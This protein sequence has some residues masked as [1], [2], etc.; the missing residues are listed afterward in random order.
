MKK[1]HPT[2]KHNLPVP[3]KISPVIEPIHV[4]KVKRIAFYVTDETLPNG[5]KRK[6]I[7]LGVHYIDAL[8]HI[9]IE[10]LSQWLGKAV[11]KHCAVNGQNDAWVRIVEH[12]IIQALLAKIER[13]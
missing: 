1:R 11:D 12:C 9:G 4:G 6:V 7:A 3:P 8:R 2:K 13:V 10:N 5:K